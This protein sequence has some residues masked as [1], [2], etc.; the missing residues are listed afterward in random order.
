MT[1]R[2]LRRR[3]RASLFSAPPVVATESRAERPGTHFALELQRTVGNRA[4]GQL[5]STPAVRPAI[6]IGDPASAHEREADRVADRVMRMPLAGVGLRQSIRS[7]HPGAELQRCACGCG[8]A[9]SCAS[10]E[11]EK[12][13]RS[14]A[15]ASPAKH[16]PS[17]VHDVVRSSGSPLDSATRSYMEPRFGHDFSHVRI[18]T[19]DRA[20]ES[21]RS[22]NAVA[23]A[24]GS[25]VVFDRGRYAPASPEGRRLIAHELTH[26]VQQRSAGEPLVQRELVYASGYPRPFGSDAAEVGCFQHHRGCKWSPSSVDFHA[27]ATN[28]GGGSG[29]ATFSALLDH[30]AAAPP[31]S[32]SELGLIGHANPTW[33]SMG[34]RITADDVLFTDAGVIGAESIEREKTRIAAL[35]N[36]FKKDAQITLYG[37]NAGLGKALLDALRDAFKV[38]VRGFTNEI[39][40]CIRWNTPRLDIFSRGRAWVATSFLDEPGRVGCENFH[41]QIRDLIPD[42]E[43]CV[44]VPKQD[45][46]TPNK[47]PAE[48]ARRFGLS[49]MVGAAASDQGWRAAIDLGVQYSLRRGKLLIVDPIIGAHL[50]YLPPGDGAGHMAA[51][52]AEI[53]LRIRQP[54]QGFYVDA[55]VGGYAGFEL[56]GDS[57]P[58]VVGGFTAAAGAGY[59]WERVEIGAQTRI[60]A[61]AGSSAQVVVIGGGITW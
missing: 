8:G 43:S 7:V 51:A 23:Y 29:A 12:L 46:P 45:T 17:V 25:H 40:T 33:F 18:H 14:A 20:A 34:G 61:G 2:A 31:D 42:Q 41:L 59:R 28:S 4:V 38:C 6:R 21:A 50:L 49:G 5:L 36:R 24:V 48:P 9:G 32:I 44:E 55:R 3:Q 57:S 58:S 19:D 47:A 10:N 37:C 35:R 1:F 39:F 16:A 56:P 53:G 26:V 15:G 11:E 52:L 30:I 13:H 27:T 60:L 54:R 22:V